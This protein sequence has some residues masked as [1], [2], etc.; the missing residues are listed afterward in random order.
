[1]SDLTCVQSIFAIVGVLGNLGSCF[2]LNN[3]SMRNTFN[4]LLVTLALSDSWYLFGALLE[5]FRSA[6]GLGTDTHVLLFPYFLY[7]LHQVR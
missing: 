3:R 4:L 1:M 6:F 7:P 2:I 5:S